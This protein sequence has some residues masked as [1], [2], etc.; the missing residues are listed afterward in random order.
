[1][2]P[3][4]YVGLG[5]RDMVDGFGSFEDLEKRQ[6]SSTNC[7][8][9]DALTYG[10]T[11]LET[12]M[13]TPF[14]RCNPSSTVSNLC[15]TDYLCACQQSGTSRCLPTTVA[16]NTDC[17]VYTGPSVLP[18]VTRWFLSSTLDYGADPS[19]QC[20]GIPDTTAAIL[21]TTT[22][23]ECPN[24]QQCVC[25]KSG[26]YSGCVDTTAS[27]F[28]GT[29]CPNT[30]RYEFKVS[31]PPPTATAK[32]GGQCGGSC[33]TGPTNCPSGATCFTETSPSPGAF[34]MCHTTKPSSTNKL[35]LKA[36]GE[37]GIDVPARV[38]ARA[39]PIYF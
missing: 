14:G 5:R 27:S 22:K 3:G 11:T 37:E 17:T 29:D 26:Q 36:R 35:R 21:W 20:G 33:W 38:Q 31:L 4:K 23:T 12:Y 8:C 15:P 2:S 30:C 1:M 9:P 25:T 32:I 16:P 39:T 19:G 28:S 34:A 24:H 6:A 10:L 13:A 18:P 7:D